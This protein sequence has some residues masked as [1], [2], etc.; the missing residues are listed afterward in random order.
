MYIMLGAMLALIVAII[1]LV[2]WLSRSRSSEV[3]AKVES[4]ELKQ[5]QENRREGDQIMA[6]PVAD[7]DSWLA[8]ARARVAHKLRDARRQ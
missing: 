5:A 3:K 2:V 6:E 7:E 8:S 4:K 1:V